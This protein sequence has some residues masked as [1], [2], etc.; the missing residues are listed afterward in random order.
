MD[1]VKNGDLFNEEFATVEE[2]LER[3][4]Y[5]WNHLTSR[6]KNNR[7][8]YVLESVNPDEEAENH[9][10]GNKIK[11]FEEDHKM[12]KLSIKTYGSN[13][14]IFNDEGDWLSIY[15]DRDSCG[16]FTL[17]EN[18]DDYKEQIIDK[19]GEQ[20]DNLEEILHTISIYVEPLSQEET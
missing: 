20:I 4:E 1:Q 19:F 5:V 16:D 17:E 12:N 13:A 18:M 3:A 2:A 14:T 8:L 10:D 11:E 6:E 9:F 15:Y 7:E